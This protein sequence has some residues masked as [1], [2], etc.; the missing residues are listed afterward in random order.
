MLDPPAPED[1]DNIIA[2]LKQSDRVNSI[3]LT[4]TNSLLEKLTTLSEP[5]SE[6]EELVLL[7]QDK[8]QL[9]LPGAFRWGLRLRTLHVTR[10]AIPA[11]PQRLSSSTNIVELQLHEIPMAGYFTPQAFANVLSGASH[12]QSLSLHFLSFPPRR[13]YIGLPPLGSHRIVLPTLTCFKYRGIS[14]YLDSFVA[15]IDA[16][17][18]K[19]IDITFFSQPTMDASELGQFIERIDMQ[20][21]LTEADIQVTAHAI[22]ISVKNSSTSTLLRLQI[23]CQQLDWQMSSMAQVCDQFS[24]F[25]FGIQHIAL[26]TNDWSSGND[27][28]EGGQWLQLVRSF[29]GALTISIAGERATG[30]FCALRPADEGNTT[31]TAVQPVL[32]ALHTLR[33]R[34]LIPLDW[35]FWDAAQSLI[36]SRGLSGHPIGLQ[37][38]CNECD[39]DFTSRDFKKHLVARHAYEFVCS[40]CGDFR[41]TLAY[42]HRFQEH[43]RKIHP[44]IAQND[45]LIPQSPSE[46]TPLQIDT[47]V[48]RH[49][50]LRK[51]GRSLR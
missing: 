50:S 29:G 3:T 33:I 23:S 21:S 27:D 8:L 18:L 48:N 6:L 12:L 46:L 47:L 37:L 4:L 38:P 9:N 39:A 36:T 10:I 35:P 7:S 26:N 20:T 11:L 28:V 5:L 44:E 41:S 40:Y 15:R 16:P 32:P 51:K 14:K 49:S 2:A 17:R 13:N 42:I 25:L 34:R 43:L 45:T 19:D 31:N 24:P 1:N 22:S 30:L